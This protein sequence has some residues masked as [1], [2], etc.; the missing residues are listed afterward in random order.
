MAEG[1][2]PIDGSDVLEREF[3]QVD[4]RIDL[5]FRLEILLSQAIHVRA[6]ALRELVKFRN[7]Q[8]YADGRLV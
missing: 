1:G 6:K 8:G 4:G 3:A 7:G 2:E 5:D